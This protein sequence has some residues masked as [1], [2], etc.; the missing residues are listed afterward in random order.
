VTP[1]RGSPLLL[2]LLLAL[3]SKSSAAEQKAAAAPGGTAINIQ[4]SHNIV[5]IDDPEVQR[6]LAELLKRQRSDEF[7]KSQVTRSQAEADALKRENEQ[8]KRQL[9]EACA[10]PSQP[11]GNPTPRPW[12]RQRSPD[13]KGATHGGRRAAGRITDCP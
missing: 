6:L 10:P 7:L 3:L 5:R 1:M 4:G 2:A 9:A 12:P 8:L 11:A 13:W